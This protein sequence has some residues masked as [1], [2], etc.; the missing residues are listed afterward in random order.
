MPKGFGLMQRSR[1]FSD[2]SDLE[3]LYHKRPGV[4]VEPRGDWGPGA[5]TLVEIPSDK[6]IY[7]NIVA[8]WRPRD[9]VPEG[10]RLDLS[11]RL[12]WC[13]EAPVRSG[14]AR[15]LNTRMGAMPGPST[16][17][18]GLSPSTSRSTRFSKDRWNRSRSA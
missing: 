3:A 14:L 10:G 17:M 13:A 1:R 4:W 15:V 2:F 6:E 16:R 11:Y 5:V 18:G 9:P 7:D 8:Y 12:T